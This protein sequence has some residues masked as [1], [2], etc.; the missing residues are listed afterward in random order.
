[1][2]K[3]SFSIYLI[4]ILMYPHLNIIRHGYTCSR[5]QKYTHIFVY[6]LIRNISRVNTYADNF[7]CKVLTEIKIKSY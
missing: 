3:N 6:M 5:T 1:M 4:Y 2:L 7:I